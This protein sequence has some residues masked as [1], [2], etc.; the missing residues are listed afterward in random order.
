MQRAQKASGSADQ[1]SHCFPSIEKSLEKTSGQSSGACDAFRP[2]FQSQSDASGKGTPGAEKDDPDTLEQIREKRFSEGLEAGNIEA[3]RI[4]ERELDAPIR[5]FLNQNDEFSN[6]F[7][8]ITETYS[9]HILELALAITQKIIGDPSRLNAAC[10][11]P[12]R[13]QL[14]NCLKQHYQLSVHFNSDDI[15]SLT[16]LLECVRPRW[17]RSAALNISSDT[18]IPQGRMQL[19]NA[20]ETFDALK[21]RF[22]RKFEEMI[23]GL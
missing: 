10:L 1:N 9:D 6:S 5:H 20:E 8:K 23:S 7:D 21:E 16:G 13:R 4:V 17:N 12:M 11:E 14:Q 3:C 15:E 2:L 19:E 18:E 22:I